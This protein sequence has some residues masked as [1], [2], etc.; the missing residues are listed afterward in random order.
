VGGCEALSVDAERDCRGAAELVWYVSYGS[1][2]SRTRFMAYLEGGRVAG[3]DVVYEGCTDTAPPVDDVALEVPHSLYFAGWSRRVWGGTAAAFITL[4][5][6]ASPALARAY[7]ITRDQFVEV[8]R[9]ENA[10]LAGVDDFDAKVEEARRLGHSR[11]LATG[12]YCE[13]IHCGERDGHPMLSFSASRD[14]TDFAPP[15]QA[16]L[17][18]IGSGLRECHGLSGT[19][20]V[21]YLRDRPG[22]QGKLSHGQ[23]RGIFDT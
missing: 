19:E 6:R 7:L 18:V 17:R 16:Y 20:V 1:N 3:N 22:I 10:N 13:L 5:T 15:S 12:P 4:E 21:D 9:Q 2:L 14:R 11:M 8:I 23:L